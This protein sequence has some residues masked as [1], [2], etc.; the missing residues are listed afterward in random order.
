MA[1]PVRLS[2]AGFVLLALVFGIGAFRLGFTAEGLPGPGLLPLVTSVLLLPVGV[3]LVLR[4]R[5]VG[6]PEPFRRGPILALAVLALYAVALPR[7]GFVVSTPVFLVAWT[8]AFHGRSLAHA[9]ALGVALTLAGVLLFRSL[10]GVPIPLW[11]GS[12]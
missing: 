4:P 9:A 12:S 2:G 10:L 1:A 5:A 11:P 6:T 3:W 7:A 8:M